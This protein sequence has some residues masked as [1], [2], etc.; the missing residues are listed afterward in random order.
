M[1]YPP[2]H[3]VRF[4]YQ[5]HHL[6]KAVQ[7]WKVDNAGE[8]SVPYLQG[9]CL[10]VFADTTDAA[11]PPYCF[12]F[13]PVRWATINRLS[14]R[15]TIYYADVELGEFVNYLKWGDRIE[16]QFKG[17]QEFISTL[18]GSPF[19]RMLA[20]GTKLEV[21]KAWDASRQ[22]VPFDKRD[23]NQHPGY[24]FLQA[25]Y[26]FW[27]WKESG[28]TDAAWEGTIDVLCKFSCLST[29]LFFKIDGLFKLSRRFFSPWKTTEKFLS[30][31]NHA[32]E[33]SYRLPAG[34]MVILKLLFYRPD[35][36][37]KPM[38]SVLKVQ[39]L[40]DGFA[41]VLPSEIRI[42]SR[43]NEQRIII[44]CKR[45]LDNIIAPILI[46]EHEKAESKGDAP[47]PPVPTQATLV[48]EPFLMA[49]I[50]VA[51]FAV[52]WIIIGLVFGGLFL[53]IGPDYAKAVGGWA[54]V[55]RISP[56]FAGFLVNRPADAASLSKILAGIVT[57]VTGFLG[58]RKVPLGK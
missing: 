45:V 18:S 25:E 42:D 31:R 24:L 32:V 41:G 2:G 33:T 11:K 13:F 49:Q 53:S 39:A 38:I 43:Y 30:P 20:D 44:A 6:A 40:G 16:E 55:Q 8:V 35:S 1:C 46:N 15:G 36:A 14:K 54:W 22:V 47:V 12:K 23:V 28:L 56:T 19:P 4:R 51:R 17:C 26:D 50:S 52:F 57:L 5:I 7:D 3:I 48:A 58:L 9:N 34:K 37:P 10:I 29:S 27:S 21:G